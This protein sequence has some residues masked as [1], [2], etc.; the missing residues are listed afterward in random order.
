M[1]MKTRSTLFSLFLSLILTFTVTAS[2]THQDIGDN[3]DTPSRTSDVV[4]DCSLLVN[5]SVTLAPGASNAIVSW[6]DPTA[7]TSCSLGGI[8]ITQ[9]EGDS[10][11]TAFPTG[12]FAIEYLAT[13]ECS[14]TAVCSFAI[15]VNPMPSGQGIIFDS[16]VQNIDVTLA[17]GTHNQVITWPTP[18]ATSTCVWG[19]LFIAQIMG[20]LNGSAFGVGTYTIGYEATD[21]CLNASQYTFLVNVNSAPTSTINLPCQTDM[22]VTLKVG[23]KTKGVTWAVP[24]STTT[25]NLGGLSIDQI[26]GPIPGSF[27]KEGTYNVTYEARDACLT[28][29]DCS[30]DIVVLPAPLAISD[31]E[32]D[33]GNQNSQEI[34][35][36][37]SA[38]IN[39]AKNNNIGKGEGF[40]VWPSPTTG[41]FKVNL[42]AVEGKIGDIKIVN[43]IGMMIWSSGK[44]EFSANPMEIDLSDWPN[45]LYQVFIV[46]PYEQEGKMLSQTVILSR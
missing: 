9:I 20:K 46:L 34:K 26:H 16:E 45:G 24:H 11:G 25:C 6:D 31:F 38:P 39:Y 32:V 44:R 1:N 15:V 21:S 42:T 35:P 43:S 5:I 10:S 41:S 40:Q 28:T 18:S 4:L 30:F 29:S 19:G 23:K 27:L 8:Q 17:P 7:T 37:D 2:V 22:E 14:S 33:Q 36:N 12:E 13:D 3:A